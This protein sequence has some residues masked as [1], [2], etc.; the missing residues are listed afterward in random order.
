MKCLQTSLLK[1]ECTKLLRNQLWRVLWRDIM[2]QL[3]HMA[4]LV[5]GKLLHW[6]DLVKKTLLLGESWFVQW[7]IF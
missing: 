5:L 4:R 7:R 6:E 2:V 1:S 3:W